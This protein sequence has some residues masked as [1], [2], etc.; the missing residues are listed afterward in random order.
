MG[1]VLLPNDSLSLCLP[2][3]VDALSLG[4]ISK[5]IQQC[6]NA[7]TVTACY[8]RIERH[9]R[10]TPLVASPQNFGKGMDLRAT[11]QEDENHHALL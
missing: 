3:L 9:S 7:H 6:R 1:C 11:K 5:E 8:A 2:S 10:T 4:A